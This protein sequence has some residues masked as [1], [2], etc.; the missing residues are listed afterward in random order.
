MSSPT[1]SSARSTSTTSSA[2]GAGSAP[3]RAAVAP[4]EARWRPS[5]CA[6]STTSI[7]ARSRRGNSTA[8][9]GRSDRARSGPGGG[10]RRRRHELAEEARLALEEP[11]RVERP[12]EAEH[13]EVEVVAE[14]V[15]ERAQEGPERDD[16]RV[17]RRPHPHADERR[18]ALQRVEP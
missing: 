6:A 10:L 1:T 4:T 2:A 15:E 14:L 3:S 5:T 11:L 13:L 8:G 12:R 18:V 7:W 17:A 9:A 16:A